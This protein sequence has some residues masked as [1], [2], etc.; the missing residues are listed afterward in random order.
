MEEEDELCECCEQCKY[1]DYDEE[2]E[3]CVGCGMPI[4]YNWGLKNNFI[5]MGE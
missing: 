2:S 4:I 5:K 3:P 1:R